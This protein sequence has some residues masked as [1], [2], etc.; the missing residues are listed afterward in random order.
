SYLF[1]PSLRCLVDV[2]EFGLPEEAPRRTGGGLRQRF[3]AIAADDSVLLWGGGLW[4]WL[5][6]VVVID[7]AARLAA[8]RPDVRL[9]F[10]GVRHPNAELADSDAA[11]RALSRADELGVR[12]RVVFFN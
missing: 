4:D 5:D 11:G 12:D 1:D 10:M 7:G 9:V 3:P 2:L 6:P 8:Q